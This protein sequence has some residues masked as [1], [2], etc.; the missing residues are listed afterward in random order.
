MNLF[1]K[2]VETD[3]FGRTRE[4]VDVAV[5]GSF[6]DNARSRL[7]LCPLLA[8]RLGASQRG[9]WGALRVFRG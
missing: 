9:A 3:G 8:L 1:V 7:L 6:L 2:V 5:R 4:G